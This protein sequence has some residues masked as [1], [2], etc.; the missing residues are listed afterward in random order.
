MK[1]NIHPT[2]HP[3]I[4]VNCACGSSFVTGSTRSEITT[5]IC[6][7]CHPFY[8][9]KQKLVDTTGLVDK[10][11]KRQAQT[12]ALKDKTVTKKPRKPRTQS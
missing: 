7:A 6:K 1:K 2:Y 3:T 10:F 9:G 4:N 5:E 11:Q 8:T 12:Q